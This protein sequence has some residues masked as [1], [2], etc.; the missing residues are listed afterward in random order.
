MTS[1]ATPAT[2]ADLEATKAEIL[3]KLAETHGSPHRPDLVPLVLQVVLSAAIGFAVWRAQVGIND[4]IDS[5]K[6]RLANQLALTQD[7]FR[8]RMKVYADLYAAALRV[9]EEAHRTNE[10]AA[11]GNL[12]DAIFDLNKRKTVDYLYS[13]ESLLDLATRLWHDGVIL[14]KDSR[15]SRALAEIDRLVADIGSQM[16]L[17]LSIKALEAASAR[18]ATDDDRKIPRAKR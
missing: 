9:S 1:H 5:A 4:R 2:R 6:T 16:R 3:A 17:E 7:Y 14:A 8:E 13:S 15:Q 12:T 18:I 11:P 10:T